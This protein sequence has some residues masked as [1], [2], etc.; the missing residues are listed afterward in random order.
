M[1]KYMI[2]LAIVAILL[3][4]C[5]SQPEKTTE[6]TTTI[7]PSVTTTTSMP[8]S[9]PMPTVPTTA[10]PTIQKTASA[11]PTATQTPV[12]LQTGTVLKRTL[13]RGTGTLEIDNKINS[14]TIMSLSLYSDEQTSLFKVYIRAADK[15]TISDIP[16]GVYTLFYMSG[17]D[18]NAS[19]ERFNSMDETSKFDDSLAYDQSANFWS[20]T[21]YPVE[22]GNALTTSVSESEFP[23]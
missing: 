22:G 12:R 10:I 1:K 20:A 17:K 2:L 16:D 11:S 6:K 9:T 19:A 8:I 13:S 4:S 18:W 23:R 14:D 7:S 3:S 15:Y 21:L 5:I